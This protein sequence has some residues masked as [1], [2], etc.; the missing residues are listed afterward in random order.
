MKNAFLFPWKTPI[1]VLK[2]AFFFIL[3]SISITL[4]GL[5]FYAAAGLPMV[6]IAKAGQ[7]NQRMMEY[8]YC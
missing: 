1:I 6:M 7:Y 4:A 3:M 8:A 5:V 2:L